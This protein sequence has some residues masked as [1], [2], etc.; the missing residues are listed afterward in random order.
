MFPCIFILFKVICKFKA[1]QR[2]FFKKT[3]FTI[4]LTSHLGSIT[5]TCVTSAPEIYSS[6]IL[7]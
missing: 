1:L 7:L 5:V 3:F 6:L 4:P 2:P